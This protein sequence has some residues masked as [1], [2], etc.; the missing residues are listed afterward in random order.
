VS[1]I[2]IRI[3]SRAAEVRAVTARSHHRARMTIPYYPRVIR[4]AEAA[5]ASANYS[6]IASIRTKQRAPRR[7]CSRCSGRQA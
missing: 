7:S 3:M 6:L 5:R 4:G 2:I 1:S